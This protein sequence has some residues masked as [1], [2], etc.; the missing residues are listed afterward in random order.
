MTTRRTCLGILILAA[1]FLPLTGQEKSTPLKSPLPLKSPQGKKNGPDV[2]TEVRRV[3]AMG[4]IH[5]DPEALLALLR[6]AELIGPNDT[7]W[8]G[9]DTHLVLT[10][11]FVDRGPNT[12][13]V[14]DLLMALEPQAQK[15]GGRVHALIGNHEAMNIYGDLRYVTPEDFATYRNKDSEKKRDAQMQSAL[16]QLKFN[17]TPPPDE[18]AW[19]KQ[20]QAQIPLGWVEHRLAFLPDGKY[21]KWLLKQSAVI[22]IDDSMYLHG[23]IS[24]KYVAR[25]LK[26]MNEKIRAELSDQRNLPGSIS[27]DEEGPLWYRGLAES[28]ENS[29]EINVLV[30][31]ILETQAVKHI[32]IGHTPFA[33]IIPRFGGKVITIDVGLSQAFESARA[34]L[35]VEDG[36]Y[37]AVHRGQ[38]LDLP[39]SGGS[40]L[41][42]LVSAAFFE[43]QGSRLR[44]M[45]DRMVVP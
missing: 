41:Q 37:Y 42:Y 18:A 1:A 28:N 35:L 7:K 27:Q 43:P 22:R 32:V 21:G 40:V 14:L 30:N 4:D 9:G 17:G 5:A 11:D 25:T 29:E 3:V 2:F 31:R 33:A 26:E 39:V 24:S 16:E 19:R 12:A 20:F 34:F 44:T 36:K 45:V 10:G 23:G 6:Q 13:A 15:A 8:T 38:K